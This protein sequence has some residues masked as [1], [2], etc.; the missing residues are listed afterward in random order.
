MAGSIN[1]NFNNTQN[2]YNNAAQNTNMQ[3]VNDAAISAQNTNSR[4]QSQSAEGINTLEKSPKEDVFISNG[5]QIEQ[6]NLV[7]SNIGPA[8]TADVD[9]QNTSVEESSDNNLNNTAKTASN[10]NSKPNLGVLEGPDN[11]SKTPITDSINKKKEETPRTK[12]P[13]KTKEKNKPKASPSGKKLTI[14]QIS[15]LCSTGSLAIVLTLLIPKGIS[16]IGKIIK[17]K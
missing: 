17:H 8:E 7:D 9:G 6:N 1:P 12:L 16:K 13:K 15:A 14:G 2:T 3:G 5:T 10:Q 4:G 11:Y